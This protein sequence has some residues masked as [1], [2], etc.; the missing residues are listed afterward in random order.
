MVD[1]PELI[2]LV[3]M[4]SESTN[5]LCLAVYGCVRR[6]RRVE[7]KKE[8]ET[9]MMLTQLFYTSDIYKTFWVFAEDKPLLFISL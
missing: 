7:R 8:R 2:E 9:A 4:E 1:D 6:T 5:P 3:E